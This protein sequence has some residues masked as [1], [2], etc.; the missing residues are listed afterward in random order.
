VEQAVRSLL[1]SV[2]PTQAN[3]VWLPLSGQRATEFAAVCEAGGVI[4]RAFAGDGVRVSIG[5]PEEND[6]F[7]AIAQRFF[8]GRRRS[9][10]RTGVASPV[11]SR[12]G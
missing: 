1:P 11:A 3:F 10:R 6:D 8:G 4:V 9:Q 2:P 7:L 12:R 5:T